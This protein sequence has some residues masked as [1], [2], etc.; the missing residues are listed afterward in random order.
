VSEGLMWCSD[1]DEDFATEMG[2]AI[3]RFYE[4]F[5]WQPTT[6]RMICGES[7]HKKVHGIKIVADT[8]ITPG[9]FLLTAEE[10][11]KDEA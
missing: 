8:T 11:K 6:C 1:G 10:I 2:W 7:L 3:R 9:H 5:G 4:R